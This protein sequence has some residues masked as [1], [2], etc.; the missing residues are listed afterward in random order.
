MYTHVLHTDNSTIDKFHLII[1]TDIETP[2]NQNSQFSL[3]ANFRIF[4]ISE[5]YSK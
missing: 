2:K 5:L 1:E 4:S 3:W